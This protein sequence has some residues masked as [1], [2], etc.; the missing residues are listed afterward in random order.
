MKYS[1]VFPD[2][3][4]QQQVL[5]GPLFQQTMQSGKYWSAVFA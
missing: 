1:L 2:M 4:A 5:R 3:L